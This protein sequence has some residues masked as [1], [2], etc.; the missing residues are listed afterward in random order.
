MI[1]LATIVPYSYTYSFGND[2]KYNNETINEDLIDEI[3][4]RFLDDV[5][6]TKAKLFRKEYMKIVEKKAIWIYDSAEIRKRVSKILVFKAL[7]GK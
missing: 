6:D 3:R 2:I 7:S 5:F 4:E 1:K